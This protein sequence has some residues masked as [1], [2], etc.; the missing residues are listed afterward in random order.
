MQPDEYDFGFPI[1]NRMVQTKVSLPHAYIVD[2]QRMS[3]GSICEQ[4]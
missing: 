3:Q 1:L 2:I 4:R